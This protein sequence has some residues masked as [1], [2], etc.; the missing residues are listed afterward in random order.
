MKRKG[1]VGRNEQCPC[2][3][4]LKYKKC[5]LDRASAQPFPYH[6]SAKELVRFRKG[7]QKCLYSSFEG[8][9]C[10]EKVIEA[11]TISRNAALTQIARDQ[12]VYL[13][14]IDPFRIAKA[15]G[16]PGLRLEYIRSASTFTGFC[17][18]HDS[19][20]FR[21]IDRGEIGPTREQ[22][23]LFHY[24]SMCRELYVKRPTLKTNRLLREADRGKSVAIQHMVQGLVSAREVAIKDALRQLEE[25]KL[26]CDEALREAD[27]GMLQGA[28]VRF[29][30]TPSLACAGYTQ[31]TFDFAGTELQDLDDMSKPLFNLSFTLLP[32]VVG[33]IAIFAWLPNADAVCRPFVQSFMAVSDDR[34]SDALVKYVFD[35][36]ENF[37]AEPIWWESLPET[38]LNALRMN[39]MNGTDMAL[40]HDT[41]ALVPSTE[42]Y[43]D[44]E[45]Q[46][47]GWF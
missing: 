29:H 28:F 7:E 10:E 44:W 27:Y 39:L 21:P 11:H 42:R 31:P 8:S 2:G 5:H 23:L 36:F 40:F 16:E 30:K 37:A 3:S 46:E 45:I 25:D 22:A 35:S 19:T 43:A 12:K 6:Q 17:S 24:R 20:L 1:R 41:C 14:D 26:T 18:T 32:D 34:K 15:G 4:G 47:T 33:G 13:L 38:C 9:Q